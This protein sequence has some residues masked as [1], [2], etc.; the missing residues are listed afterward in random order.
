MGGGPVCHYHSHKAKFISGSIGTK[1][2]VVGSVDAVNLVVG[3]HNGHRLCLFDSDF[4][5]L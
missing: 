5:A 4:K 1:V 3:G 2:V